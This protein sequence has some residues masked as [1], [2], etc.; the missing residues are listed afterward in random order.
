MAVFYV[1][2]VIYENGVRKSGDAIKSNHKLITIIYFIT[3]TTDNQPTDVRH[4][5]YQT[6]VGSGII[7][8]TKK[9][10]QNSNPKNDPSLSIDI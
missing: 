2:L 7:G 6:T 9:F 10:N 8:I 1:A 5:R 3:Q 4:K